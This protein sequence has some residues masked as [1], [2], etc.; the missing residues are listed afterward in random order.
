V[1]SCDYSAWTTPTPVASCTPAAQSN[2]PTN[3]TRG[4]AVQCSYSFAAAAPTQTCSPAYV[5]GNYSNAHVYTN[6][7]TSNPPW[8]NAGSCTT[9]T[10]DASGQSVQCQ[11]GSWSGWSTVASC[12]AV[13]PSTGPNYTVG[14]ARQCQTLSSG[15]TSNTL[16]D[17]AAYYY[18]TDLR[19]ATAVDP[20]DTGTCTGPIIAPSSTANDLCADNVPPFG[21]DTNAKQHMTT[22][23][24]GLGAQGSMVFS[25][26]QNNL[27]GQRVY[28]PDYWQQQ[29][30]DFYAVAN[31]S[32]ANPSSG[33]CPWMSSGSTCTWPTPSSDSIN[34]IDDLW[35]AAVNGRGTY[36]SATDPQSLADSLK[37]A[38]SQIVNTP[39]PGTAAAAASSNPNITSSDNYVFSSSYKS[40]EW[41]GE[42]IMQQLATDGSLGSQQWSAMRNLDCTASAWQA[43]FAYSAGAAFS[44]GGACYVVNT[45]YTSGAT[46]DGTSSGT[47]GANISV[48]AGVTPGTRTI[49]VAGGADPSGLTTFAWGNLSAAQ[50]AY[51]SVAALTYVD[52]STGITQF[53]SVG[54]ACLSAAAQ[55][56]A[57][58]ANLVAFLAGQRTYEGSYYRARKHVLGD[59]VS[60]E[61]RYVKQ[62]LQGYLDA[63]YQ[64][65]KSSNAGRTAMVYVGANDGMV[66]AFEGLTGKEAW[67]FIPSAVLPT[68]Y[69][70]ADTDY[71]NK[72]W[73][74]VDG[75]PE[76]GDICPNSP[77]ACSSTQWKTILV[78]GLNDGGMAYYAL[79][80]TDPAAPKLL[81]QF[82]NANLGL[83]YSNPR[84]TKLKDGTWVVI[85]ASG[86]N[87]ADGVGRLFVLNASTGSLIRTISTGVGSAGTPSGLAKIAARAPT[88]A[89]DNTVF[90]VYGGDLLGNVWRFDVNND[91]GTSGYDAQLLVNLQDPSGHAQP[92]TAKP[93]V[94]T[95]NNY[96]M[97]MFGTGQ[98]LGIP[99]LSSTPTNTMYA[100]IDRLGT[101]TLTTPRALNSNFVH[102]TMI[103]TTCPADAP[104][105]VCSQGQTVRTVQ[106]TS[107][108]WSVQNGWYVD[109]VIDGERSVTDPT[110]ALG[111]LA[112]TTIKPQT[113]T[114]GTVTS[115][116]GTDTA[117]AAT[118]YL[119]YL[120]YLTGGAVDGTK[121]VVGNLLCTCVATRPSVV[122][123]QTGNVEAIIRTSG[124]GNSS[125]T[126]MGNTSRQ[127]L[128]YNPG[129]SGLRRVSWRDLNGQ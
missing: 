6:C 28:Q 103:D 123:T 60:S 121:N 43:N 52:A 55:T 4:V 29:S 20:D 118:S 65:F 17:V 54:A 109:F 13:D 31:G 51:F 79:D 107:V 45:D 99:D 101:S 37:A 84:I 16:A 27:A 18:T 32:T 41:Y 19:S 110:L 116:T 25:N 117:V 74:F 89:T 114:S 70:L 63:G 108:D 50:K 119:Y 1:T 111:T 23:T 106:A 78:G 15:G 104:A 127:D 94:A 85:V 100:I 59:I 11:Y 92:I 122:R 39:R 120:N 81:W 24:L 93:T 26:Y 77:A 34:N 2:G 113:S 128:P 14:T 36:F 48:M 33:I 102:Q 76:V 88:S 98:Y 129:G 105:S 30:G 75:T 62:P 44:Q 58:G 22:S 95:V 42:L 35:H 68:M 57:A 40:V 69:H 5:N 46:F 82:T 71:A 64:D 112:F 124:G 67:A 56:D 49:Y 90:Q 7:S 97:V 38:L 61:A 86:Y 66:H 73:Y 3:Y 47:D 8:T 96:P 9:S 126:D 125:G 53:C 21:R 83:S 91:I 72:H 115:C 12:T 87:N 10:F 80:I